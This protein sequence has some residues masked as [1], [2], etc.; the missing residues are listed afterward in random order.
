MNDGANGGGVTISQWT[1]PARPQPRPNLDEPAW[2]VRAP[3]T[4]TMLWSILVVGVLIDVVFHT[5]FATLSAFTTFCVATVLLLRS[6]R[7]EHRAAKALAL[8][9]VGF[10]IWLVLR[11]S[12]WLIALDIGAAAGLLIAAA[13]FARSRAPWTTSIP[14]FVRRSFVVI[15]HGFGS[16]AFVLSGVKAQPR[17]RIGPIVRGVVLALPL[18]FILGALLASA[19]AVFASFFDVSFDMGATIGHLFGIAIGCAAMATLLRVASAA[20]EPR[21]VAGHRALRRVEMIVILGLLDLLFGLWA[22]AQLLAMSSAGDHV[23]KTQGLTYA[24]YARTGFFQLLAVAGI[25][26]SIVMSVRAALR[27]DDPESQR[28]FVRLVL[29]LLGLT[30]A[31]VAVSIQRLSL[32]EHEFGWTSL[33]L[34]V[35]ISAYGIG[36]LVVLLALSCTAR[37]GARNWFPSAGV[38]VV[39]LTLLLVNVMNPDDFVTRHNVGRAPTSARALDGLYLAQLSDDAIPAAV[40]GLDS[41][42]E[43]ERDGLVGLLCQRRYSDSDW[44]HWNLSARNADAAIRSLQCST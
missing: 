42:S 12:G 26:I 39:C 36:A 27:D 4:R 37:F 21:P 16:V 9:S 23:L 5:G 19:D 24:Q 6:G 25:T 10:S 28:W 3:A 18:L 31:I 14:E 44:L 41:L 8:G 30:L 38:V 17:G 15:A 33:R 43:S 22:L 32:Y 13:S 29:V 20:H 35:H 7:L 11:T 40:Q 34:V 2:A 1:P